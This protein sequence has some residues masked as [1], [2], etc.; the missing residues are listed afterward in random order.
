M[1]S[2]RE[3]GTFNVGP[4][5]A[6]FRH[7]ADP[8][9]GGD[10]LV[11]H[12]I[13]PPGSSA[14]IWSRAFPTGLKPD[15]I[16]VVRLGARSDPAEA[17]QVS[18]AIELKG[19]TGI[20]RIALELRP[21]WTFD[22][23]NVSWATIGALK[24]VV[25]LVNPAGNTTKAEGS[26]EFFVRF[27]RL[28]WLRKLG[29]EL[30]PRIVGVL[31]VAALAALLLRLLIPTTM[32]RGP[33]RVTRKPLWLDLVRGVGS[34]AIVVLALAVGWT[35]GA[36]PIEAGWSALGLAL[37]GGL[38]G[39]WW[40]F[41]LTGRLPTPGVLFRDTAATGLLAASSS[42][43]ALLQAPSAWTDLLRLSQTGAAAAVLVYHTVNAFQLDAKRRPMSGAVA[44][45]LV[46]AP[47]LLGNLTLLTVDP[48]LRS[49]GNLLTLG[50]IGAS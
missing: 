38:L 40:T 7:T 20:Q 22:E 9:V 15:A 10:V 14:G 45:L 27:E 47:F 32:S 12:Y 34:V 29:T 25:V 2:A 36:E 8:K 24:E 6:T 5:T 4:A 35:G 21:D 33:S 26:V 44:A 28:P 37:V 43:L 39:A 49:L 48:L 50:T 3:Q 13:L 46:A 16:D 30:T 19:T 18:A 17:R 42:A 31:L 11:L 23:P 1:T 41:G